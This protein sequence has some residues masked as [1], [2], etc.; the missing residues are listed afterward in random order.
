LIFLL[1]ICFL[2]GAVG[3]EA[4][5][6]LFG[7]FLNVKGTVEIMQK[8]ATERLPAKRGDLIHYGD[9]VWT[10]EDSR[11][12]VITATRKVVNLEDNTEMDTAGEEPR[13]WLARSLS[14]EGLFEK[15]TAAD[16]LVAVA[17]VRAELE[18]VL[19]PR[20]S[21]VKT[22]TPVIRLRELP[23]RYS[24]RI[25][26][27]GGGIPSPYAGTI[28]TDIVDLSK[29]DLHRPLDRERTYFIQVELV[30]QNG[31]LRGKERDVYIRPLET[32]ELAKITEI[33]RELARPEKDDPG[34][35]SYK[36][37]LASEYESMGLYSDALAIYETLYEQQPTDQFI[38]SQLAHMYNQTKLITELRKLTGGEE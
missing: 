15:T 13:G 19:S 24:Y 3:S 1:G 20:N 30:D 27:T 6:D 7:R 18:Y 14:M 36:L 32:E 17:G 28:D 37:L 11:A 12:T 4:P 10:G 23:P 38:R 2:A 5:D 34:N 22:T 33:E 8:G 9:K 29:T 16:A 25:K 26:I 35:P 31:S 21:A